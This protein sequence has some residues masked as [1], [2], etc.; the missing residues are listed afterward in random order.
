MRIWGKN[1]EATKMYCFDFINDQNQ[2]VNMPAGWKI[3]TVPRPCD[4]MLPLDV[5]S[6]EA[7][8]GVQSEDIR[9]G[10]EKFMVPEGIRLRISIP[11]KPSVMITFPCRDE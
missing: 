1:L 9:P 5:L 6:M 2:P 8:F 7:A 3:V 11:N 4:F 10:Q